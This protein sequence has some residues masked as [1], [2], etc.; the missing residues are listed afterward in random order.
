LGVDILVNN[1]DIAPPAA[2]GDITNEHFS[3]I[4]GTNLR[5]PLM[6]IQAAAPQLFSPARIIDIS[7]IA[8]RQ[9]FRGLTVYAASKAGL[10]AVTRH[11]AH[12]IGGDGTT[13]NCVTPS[14]V[15]S[16]LLRETDKKIPGIVDSICASTSLQHRVGTP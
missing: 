13:M 1:A 8:A 16:E 7:S 12:E 2:L 9:H 6:M 5:G 11:L 4:I 15:E 3:S 14:A 10:E